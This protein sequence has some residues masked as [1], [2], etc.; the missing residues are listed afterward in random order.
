MA[1]KQLVLPNT[2]TGDGSWKQWEYHFNNVAAANGWDAENKLK[3]LK[4]RLT[5]RA[6]IAF[7]RLPEASRA[8]FIEASKAL[9]EHFEPTTRKTHYQAELQARRKKKSESWADLADDLRLL[10][11]KA[12][13]DLEDKARETLALS[14]YLAQIDD[15]RLNFGVK[16]KAP[17]SLDEAVTATLEL[18]SYLPPQD[19]SRR[20]GARECLRGFS[21]HWS[22]E[23]CKG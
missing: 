21:I 18:E 9:G 10:A 14:A 15:S 17:Q 3:W 2:Y 7:Q 5:G 20:C 8:S 19:A 4:V 22:C 12:Y 6:Q 1:T 11:D 13:P 23:Q 16:Q